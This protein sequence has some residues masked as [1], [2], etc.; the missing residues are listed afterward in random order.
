MS[1]NL[2]KV[3]HFCGIFCVFLLFESY[4]HADISAFVS[5]EILFQADSRVATVQRGG[6]A[7]A[8]FFRRL[9]RGPSSAVPTVL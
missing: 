2:L 7:N 6:G 5:F 1:F 8:G 3:E 4:I 9:Q